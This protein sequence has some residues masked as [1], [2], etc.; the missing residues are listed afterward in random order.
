M[1]FYFNSED[2]G[3]ISI[4]AF[5]LSVPIAFSQEA[6]DLAASLPMGNLLLVV[7]LSLGF[8]ALYAYQSVFQ[9]RIRSRILVFLLRIILAYTLTLVV[10]SIVLLALDKWPLLTEPYLALKRTLL[11]AMPASMGAIIVDSFDKE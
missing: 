2:L 1:N 11:I 6:W 10:V 7:G 8:I 4:G 9:A 5:A 3:Q